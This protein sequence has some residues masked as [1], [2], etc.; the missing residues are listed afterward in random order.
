MAAQ[1]NP[2]INLPLFLHGYDNV[3]I[4]E[5]IFYNIFIMN[6][7]KI[8]GKA[9]ATEGVSERFGVKQTLPAHGNIRHY[10]AEPIF[11]GGV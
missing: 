11:Q 3:F 10:W 2:F 4:Y 6:V 1:P 5:N 7:S 8:A 9:A